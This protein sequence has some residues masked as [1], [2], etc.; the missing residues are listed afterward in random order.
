MVPLAPR[1]R[2]SAPG[3]IRNYYRMGETVS[4]GAAGPPAAPASAARH[5]SSATL[6]RSSP[7]DAACVALTPHTPRAARAPPSADGSPVRMQRAGANVRICERHVPCVQRQVPMHER[8]RRRCGAAGARARLHQFPD[9]SKNRRRAHP[10]ISC[11][12]PSQHALQEHPATMPC[13]NTPK[14]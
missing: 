6:V 3:E 9:T 10:S 14:Q 13:R 7:A 2:P 12:L 4:R 8:A 11:A 1:P 5:S